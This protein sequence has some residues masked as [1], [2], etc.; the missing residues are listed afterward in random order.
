MFCIRPIVFF[1]ITSMLC[2]DIAFSLESQESNRESVLYDSNQPLQD[3][4]DSIINKNLVKTTQDSET[5]SSFWDKTK[6]HFF[7]KT[8]YKA[9]VEKAE[10]SYEYYMQIL[11]HE[12]MYFLYSYS[13]PPQGVYGNNIRSELKFQLSAKVPIWRG[14]FWS[15]GTLFFGYTQT[16]WFQQF[17]F[18]YSNPVRDTDYKPS[19]FYSYPANWNVLGGKLKELRLGVLHYSNG[20]GGEECLR[21]NINIPTPE[22]CRS[23]S[24]GNRIML[25]IIWESHGFGIHLTAWPYIDT[26]RDNPDL[27]EFMGYANLRFYYKHKRH[28][29]EI[30][31]SPIISNYSKY[32]G[33]IRIGYALAINRFVSIYGQY[34]YGYGDNLYEYN[35]ISHRLGIGLR[36]TIF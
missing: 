25:E 28:F 22:Q 15:K 36:S 16:M 9:R 7:D 13:F 23:R 2:I 3:S 32:H 35:R 34:F 29:A 31:F 27:N 24:A 30:H 21:T 6:K 17:N 5:Q 12:G 11:E 4:Q 20:I 10:K 26:R 33:S 18:A 1:L 14:A 19:L 8:T